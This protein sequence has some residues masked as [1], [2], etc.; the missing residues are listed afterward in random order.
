MQ[1]P[2]IAGNLYRVFIHRALSRWAANFSRQDV[3]LQ[4]RLC[5]TP[6]T[7]RAKMFVSFKIQ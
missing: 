4:K 5:N 6:R 1:F 3:F 2:K 7:A